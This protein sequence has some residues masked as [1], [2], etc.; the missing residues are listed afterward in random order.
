MGVTVLLLAASWVG[1]AAADPIAARMDGP[2]TGLV[3]AIGTPDTSVAAWLTPRMGLVAHVRWPGSSV[4][5]HAATRA[6]VVGQPDGYGLDL[7]AAAGVTVPTL[8]PG[9]AASL[10]PALRSRKR[11]SGFEAGVGLAL[12]TLLGAAGDGLQ[13]RASLLVEPGVGVRIGQTW[14]LTQAS[15]GPTFVTGGRTGTTAKA[16]LAWTVPWGG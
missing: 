4:G 9:A 7:S 15:L 2:E 16:A 12:P 3:T 8:A 5:V 10:T 1:V 6:T 13:A 11:W 14:L